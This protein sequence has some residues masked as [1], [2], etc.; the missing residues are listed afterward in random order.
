MKNLGPVKYRKSIIK[1]M[2]E[3]FILKY[4]FEDSYRRFERSINRM[5]KEGDIAEEMAIEYL[6]EEKKLGE[7]YRTNMV[8]AL[9]TIKIEADIIDYDNKIIYETKSRKNGILA[10]KAIRQKWNVFMFDKDGSNYEN[11]KFYGIIVANYEIGPKVKGIANFD[12]VKFDKERLSEE[13]EKHYKRV[14]EFKKIK[15]SKGYD[16]KGN[17]TNYKKR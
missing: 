10:K 7:N 5:E 2:N 14:E 17:F 16:E 3:N 11:F 9:N 15:R 4:G 13:F 8:I 12:H 6:K 1:S